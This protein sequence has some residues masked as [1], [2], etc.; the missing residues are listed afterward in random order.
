[1][2]IRRNREN[3]GDHCRRIFVL[4]LVGQTQQAGGFGSRD[5]GLGL[6]WN[7]ISRMGG[8]FELQNPTGA[9]ELPSMDDS[10]RVVT[11]VDADDT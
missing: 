7:L 4:G 6:L 10:L 9:F 8:N 5:P 2:R 1:M 3:I 11:P